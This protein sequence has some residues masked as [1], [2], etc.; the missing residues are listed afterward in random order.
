MFY[1]PIWLFQEGILAIAQKECIRVDT[2]TVSSYAEVN[3]EGLLQLGLSRDHRPD[4]AQLKV[5]LASLDPLG[6]PLATEVLSGEQAD[7]P[8]YLPII[9]RVREGLGKKGFLYIGDCKMSALQT[10]ATLQFQ[11]DFYLCPLSSVQV[12]LDQ[13]Q[14]EVDELRKKD[15][16]VRR[17]ERVND[18]NERIC[19]A[20]G[21]ET[22]REL[23]AEVNGQVQTWTERRLLIQSTSAA[24]AAGQ[25]LRERVDKAEKALQ[26]LL[27]RKQ[28]K[29]HLKT[30]TEIDE[31]IG[32]VIKK[33]RVEGLL[34][35]IIHEEKQEYLVRAY[36]GK[37]SSPRQENLF[38]IRSEKK[39]EA[40]EYAISH[41]SWRVYATNQETDSL[42][43]EQAV[44]A[45]R[46]EYRV[47]R[48][49]ERLKGHPFSLAPMY[50]QRDDHRVGLV[51]LLTIALRVLT[52]LENIIRQNLQ[53]QKRE[54]SGLY[55]GNPKR[56]TNQPTAERLLE[57]FGDITL[58]IVRTS[59]FIHRHV[60]QLSSLQQEILAL[61]GFTPVIY[62]QLTDDS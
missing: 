38:S 61:L 39:E 36:R 48:C 1:R 24:E 34:E 3:E 30:R 44:E 5:V 59:E 58:T 15:I 17:V 35:V 42:T 29:P 46:D 20:Q 18:K 16:P 23:T 2:T 55:A 14:Q 60:T 62:L 26:Y 52:L 40:L 11:S 8:V 51:R 22:S 54:I 37:L 49:F 28:G 32:E 7:D 31:A 25:S 56:R 27:V 4:L 12:P 13:L 45:Y 57:A 33:F 43:L 19:I 50:V 47:E 10:R 9:T 53:E 21:Y 6:M 41:L